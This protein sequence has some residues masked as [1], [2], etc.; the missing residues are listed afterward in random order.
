[1][2]FVIV[3]ILSLGFLIAFHEWGHYFFARLLGMKV[4]RYSIGF[5][6]PIFSWTSQKS[7]IVY[8][9]GALP[10]GG[11]V[12]VKGMNPFEEGAFEDADS[13]QMASPWKRMLVIIAGPLANLLIAWA[14]LFGLKAISGAPEPLDEAGVGQMVPNA[15]AEKAGLETGDRILSVNGVAVKTFGDL[16]EQVGQNGGKKTVLLIQREGRRMPV[17]ITPENKQ[18]TGKIGVY[19]PFKMVRLPVGEAARFATLKSI[20]VVKD[21]LGAIWGMITRTRKDVQMSGPPQIIKEAKIQYDYGPIAYLS[22]MSFISL[23]LFLFN[24]LPIPALDGGRTVFLLYEVITR[25]RVNKRFDAML[26][27]V[28]FFILMTLLVIISAKEIF[29]G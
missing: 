20:Q 8:Q 7:G 28:F 21:T 27:T 12:Q 1:M 10:L 11:F 29:F 3:I 25:K 14:V 13:Y 22:F 24:L 16:V 15:P 23:M 18:G 17:T 9:I 6:K 26:N 2:D 5:L 19:P 4:L